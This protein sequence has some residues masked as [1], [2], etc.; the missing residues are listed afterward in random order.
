VR[1]LLVTLALLGSTSAAYAQTYSFDGYIVGTNGKPSIKNPAVTGDVTFDFSGGEESFSE[2]VY[3]GKKEIY[4]SS[5][6]TISSYTSLIPGTET[7]YEFTPTFYEPFHGSSL[8]T[9][10][11]VSPSGQVTIESGPFG[12]EIGLDSFTKGGKTTGI[13]ITNFSLASAVPEPSTDLAMLVGLGIMAY[14]YRRR[15]G[16]DFGPALGTSA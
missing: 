14:A 9:F 4:S 15:R 2:V 12:N 10:A 1:K 16:R 5:F 3:K 11:T 6:E 8:T 7:F 13:Y